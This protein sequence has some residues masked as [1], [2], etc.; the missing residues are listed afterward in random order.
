MIIAVDFDGT[1]CHES[2]PGIGNPE[3]ELLNLVIKLK[4]AGHTIILW[5]CRVDKYL[6][7]AVDWCKHWGLE[8]D[9][10]NENTKEQ[11]ELFGSDPRKIFAHVYI[12]DRA[13]SPDG[14]R[15]ITELCLLV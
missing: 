7:E 4:Q 6:E 11:K 2:Y 15:V 5:T 3:F 13:L 9:Y 1:L 14:L 12:D 8:F 10:V